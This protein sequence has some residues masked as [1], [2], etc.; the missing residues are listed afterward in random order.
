MSHEYA[1]A[2]STLDARRNSPVPHTYRGNAVSTLVKHSLFICVGVSGIR[3]TPPDAR[4]KWQRISDIG[5]TAAASFGRFGGWCG[6]FFLFLS[7][8]AFV[9][10]GVPGFL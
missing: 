8:S 10:L 5:G 3:P 6:F 1:L 7:L 2:N 4:L 9:C